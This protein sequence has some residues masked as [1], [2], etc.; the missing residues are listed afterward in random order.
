MKK[1]KKV[2][3]VCII[4]IMASSVIACN[5][6]KQEQKKPA[7]LKGKVTIWVL[8]EDESVLTY[9]AGMFQ[10]KNPKVKIDVV[11][12]AGSDLETNFTEAVQ[13]KSKL[14]DIVT[15][16]DYSISKFINKNENE[17]L[18]VSAVS[19]FNKEMF[20][21]EQIHNA[22]V[23][24]KIYALPWYV[25]PMVI[26][27]RNDLLKTLNVNSEDIKTWE[28]F[29]DIWKDKFASSGKGML[30]LS[31]LKSGVLYNAGVNQLG[32]NYL[33]DSGKIDLLSKS[34]IKPADNFYS[35]YQSK[36]FYD[37]SKDGG[38]L[39]SFVKGNV[40]S[41]ICDVNTLSN[42]EKKY[43]ALKGKLDVEK[44][45]AFEEG[46]N[47]DVISYGTNLLASKTTVNN[48]A[49]VDFMKFLTMDA[50]FASDQFKKYG[51]VTSNSRLWN[52]QPYFNKNT[53]YNNESLGRIAVDEAQGLKDVQYPEDFGIINDSVLKNLVDSSI[54]NKSLND[55]MLNFQKTYENYINAK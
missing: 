38:E 41:L 14:P 26:V 51:Y 43:P 32:I 50:G 34:N 47:R 16:N 9:A 17:L 15:L 45:P 33:N 20:I 12:K 36:I 11:S 3:L 22:T 44:L 54:N 6:P 7:E 55:S 39:E 19:G 48:K 30:S 27:Y 5:K 31:C 37:D 24:N 4:L 29:S 8:N 53:F 21:S 40:L 42:I 46:G 49:A 25:K 1:V 10:K 23:K 2:L 28:Q 52:N 13:N 18:E 35:M